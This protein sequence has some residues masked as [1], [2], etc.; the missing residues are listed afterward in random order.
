MFGF[1]SRSGSS[2]SSKVR[3]D[4]RRTVES[5]FFLDLLHARRSSLS[6]RADPQGETSPLSLQPVYGDDRHPKMLFM[7][8]SLKGGRLVLFLVSDASAYCK[9]LLGVREKKFIAW[10]PRGQASHSFDRRITRPTDTAR[11]VL[12]G[13]FG[14]TAFFNKVSDI[15]C[16]VCFELSPLSFDLLLFIPSHCGRDVTNVRRPCEWYTN[17]GACTILN[18]PSSLSCNTSLNTVS[19][20]ARDE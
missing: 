3:R 10:S 4:T 18:I 8:A 16:L 17:Q 9:T 5:L 2:T 13:Q 12:A 1:C 6:P 15:V 19:F 7:L 14:S 20:P 11:M